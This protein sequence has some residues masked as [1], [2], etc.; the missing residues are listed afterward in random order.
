MHRA[1]D[2]IAEDLLLGDPDHE[3]VLEPR[4]RMI[5]APFGMAELQ[6]AHEPLHVQREEAGGEDQHE[7]EDDVLCCHRDVNLLA[8]VR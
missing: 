2:R 1:G 7:E 6:V 5:G 8:V 4:E 3:D